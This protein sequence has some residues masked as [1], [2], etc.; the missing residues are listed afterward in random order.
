MAEVWRGAGARRCAGTYPGSA[1]L[2]PESPPPPSHTEQLPLSGSPVRR[3]MSSG[4]PG[5]GKVCL[6]QGGGLPCRGRAVPVWSCGQ[7][8]G[9]PM[10]RFGCPSAGLGLFICSRHLLEG[11]LSSA[12]CWTWLKRPFGGWQW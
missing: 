9:N 12:W 2:P 1:V 6:G 8:A 4:C 7:R 5:A 3:T 11:S 10:E